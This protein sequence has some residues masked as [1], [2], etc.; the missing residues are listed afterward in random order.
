MKIPDT[1]SVCK[2][3]LRLMNNAESAS[4]IVRKFLG[5]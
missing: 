4:K 1:V 3:N 2:H 5:I